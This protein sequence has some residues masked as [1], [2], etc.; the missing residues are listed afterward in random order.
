MVPIQSM[1]VLRFS[2]D[3]LDRAR[4]RLKNTY[5]LVNL[6]A[7]KFARINKIH[8]IQC[9]GKIFCVEFE[10]EPLKIQTKYLTQTLK[11]TIFIQYWK[12][13]SSHVYQLI[14][15]PGRAQAQMGPNRGPLLPLT[16]KDSFSLKC[17]VLCEYKS[18][19]DVIKWKHIPRNWPFVRGIHRS[20]WIPHTKASAAELWCF[21]WSASE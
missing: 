18:H 10:R 11:H 16:S 2:G 3:L 6:G 4:R 7:R 5:E 12:F 8:I 9:M 1:G 20:R 21:L 13:K 14:I 17:V 15:K 19:D